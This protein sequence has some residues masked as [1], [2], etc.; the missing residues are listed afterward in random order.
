MHLAVCAHYVLLPSVDTKKLTGQ[1]QNQMH[2]K[3]FADFS[4]KLSPNWKE[5]PWTVNP[6]KGVPGRALVHLAAILPEWSALLFTVLSL[7]QRSCSSSS[8]AQ[9]HTPWLPLSPPGRPWADRGW[10]YQ[11]QGT[12]GHPWDQGTTTPAPLTCTAWREEGRAETTSKHQSTPVKHP[13]QTYT[14]FSTQGGIWAS[15]MLN[16]RDKTWNLSPVFLNI[17]FPLLGRFECYNLSV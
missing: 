7:C 10:H 6:I 1:K 3:P 8:R 11:L 15:I 5:K 4:T 14:H 13:F 17:F 12:A 2:Q 16:I 9:A